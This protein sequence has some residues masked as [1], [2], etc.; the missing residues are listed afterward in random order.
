MHAVTEQTTW[1]KIVVRLCRRRRLVLVFVLLGP[2][3]NSSRDMSIRLF[4]DRILNR[5]VNAKEGTS[6]QSEKGK[7]SSPSLRVSGD[8]VEHSAT[9]IQIPSQFPAENPPS[10]TAA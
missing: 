6:N 9:K 2:L 4:R 7:K 8:L 3:E 1:Q 10:V 5:D